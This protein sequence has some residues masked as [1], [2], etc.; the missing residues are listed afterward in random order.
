MII[1]DG[2]LEAIFY[3]WD[4]ILMICFVAF[5]FSYISLFLFR[6]VAFFVIWIINVG[7][8][9]FL[10]FL[11]FAAIYMKENLVAVF[12]A[13]MAVILIVLLIVFRRRIGLVATL[14]RVASKALMDIPAIMFEPFLVSIFDRNIKKDSSFSQINSFV[15]EFQRIFFVCQN[16]N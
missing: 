3:T 11:T 4:S 8:I 10:I 1:A 5:C 9:V 2:S 15:P 7:C 14:F 12:M 6:Y 16:F 13:V